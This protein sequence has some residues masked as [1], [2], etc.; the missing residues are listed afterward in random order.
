MY[1]N[2]KVTLPDHYYVIT[3]QHKLVPYMIDAGCLIL[4]SEMLKGL[5]PACTI[6]CLMRIGLGSCP[7]FEKSFK[8]SIN[9][10][11]SVMI[12]S[13][14]GGPYKNRQYEKTVTFK[15]DC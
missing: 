2:Y 4:E 12:V 13:V 15:T 8:N 14:D 6:I 9:K 1:I 7:E 5:D 11:R 3:K 10:E